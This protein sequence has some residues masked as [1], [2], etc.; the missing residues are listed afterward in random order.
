ME[1]IGYE[2]RENA[3]TEDRIMFAKGSEDLRTHYL[4][5]ETLNGPIWKNHIYFR[6][7]LRLH[8]EYIH[9]YSKL[10]RDLAEKF[11][12][13][14]YLYTKEKDKFISMILEKQKKIFYKLN[15]AY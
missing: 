9:Q 10:K 14:R 13:D 8:K 1:D 15:I 2:Y 7:Y 6:D 3:C 4:H 11:E 12:D 5:I